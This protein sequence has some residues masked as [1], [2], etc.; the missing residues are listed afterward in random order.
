VQLRGFLIMIIT[1]KH[2]YPNSHSINHALHHCN[3]NCIESTHCIIAICS[4]IAS[5]HCNCIESMH[6]NCIESIHCN[7]NCIESM[8]CNCNCNYNCIAS[9]Q[10]Q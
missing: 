9:L 4:C 10:L 6:C 7:C 3:C 5:M 8:H 2:L 1:R